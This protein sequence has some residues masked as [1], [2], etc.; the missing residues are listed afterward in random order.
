MRHEKEAEVLEE[1]EAASELQEPCRCLTD[2]TPYCLLISFGTF[3]ERH[4]LP[5]SAR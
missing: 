5:F 1:R 2:G 3:G 4:V